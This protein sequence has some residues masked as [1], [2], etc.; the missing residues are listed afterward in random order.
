MLSTSS[1]YVNGHWPELCGT[2][3]QDHFDSCTPLNDS[4]PLFPTVPLIRLGL[5]PRNKVPLPTTKKWLLLWLEN[6][7]R[8]NTDPQM[9]F[10]C[11]GDYR[12]NYNTLYNTLQ[13]SL[14]QCEIWKD[15]EEIGDQVG[16]VCKV[17]F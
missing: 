5:R 2:K 7:D 14:L 12:S 11:L 3:E 15:L 4:L 13:T 16:F 6:V 1:R 10:W 8:K 9:I 17:I